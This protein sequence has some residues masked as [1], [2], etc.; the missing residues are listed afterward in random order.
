MLHYQ[1]SQIKLILSVTLFLTI[2]HNFTFLRKVIDAY[3]GTDNTWLIVISLSVIHSCML[4]IL[5][6]LGGLHKRLKPVLIILLLLSSITSYFID[7]YQV[8]FDSDMITNMIET[9]AGEVNDLLNYRLLGYFVLIGALPAYLLSKLQLI[10]EPFFQAILKRIV[11]IASC[12]IIAAATIYFSSDFYASFFRS[13]K[14]IRYYTNPTTPI[15]SLYKFIDL[16]LKVNNINEFLTV[17]TDAVVPDSDLDTELV[18]LIVGETARTDHFSLNGYKRITNPLLSQRKLVSFSNVSSCGTSTA[19]SVPCMFSFLE[20]NNYSKDKSS[21]MENVLD[22]LHRSGVSIL[23]RDNNSG[24]K[25]VASRVEYES[26]KTPVV[27]PVCNPECRDEGMLGGLNEWVNQHKSSD[28]LI[29]LH[30][31]GSHGPAYFK[32][33]PEN[34]EK[35]KPT[36]QST[37]LDN[38]T[39]EEV[40]NA[41]DNSILYTDYFVDR[42]INWLKEKSTQFETSMLYI[43]DHGESLG[44]SGLYLHGIPYALA[45][46]T[47]THVPTLFWSSEENSDIDLE[48]LQNSINEPYSHDNLFHTLLGIFEIKSE[49][50]QPEKDIL[51][52]RRTYQ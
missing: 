52:Y 32:R 5:L 42:V 8:V 11:L 17:G 6:S 16:Q 38:C 30:Q 26:Y 9:D 50:Y 15:Y 24:S 39:R 7:T 47:Q 18:I 20:Q 4:T 33:Y 22:V 13:H 45:P 40:V 49:V 1:I 31:M 36:C 28:M 29:V 10:Q 43:S 2:F 19:V 27:N 12:L 37:Q 21:S 3:A 41:Y 25:G 44:E 51:K 48:A 14:I 34:F 23:W 35:F 46:A